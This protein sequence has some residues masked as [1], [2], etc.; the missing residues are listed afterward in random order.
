MTEGRYRRLARHLSALG[1]GYPDEDG[2]EEILMAGY[3]PE[4]VEVALGLPNAVPPLQP[5]SMAAIARQ[6][7]LPEARLMPVLETMVQKG[8]L[9]TGKTAD[10]ERGYALQQFGWGFPQSWFW[11]GEETPRARD[12]ADLVRRYHTHEVLQ[13]G[14]GGTGTKAYRFVPVGE[15]ALVHRH[16]GQQAVY[17]FHMMQDLIGQAGV[18]AVAHCP[19][20]MIARLRGKGCEHP[21]EVCLK[22]DELAEY[23]IDTGRGRRVS[24]D[25][26]LQIVRQS[27]ALGMVHLVDNALEKVK[28][29][30]NCCPCSCWSVN[31]LRRRKIPRDSLMATYFLR[32]TDTERCTGCG[33]CVEVCPVAAL[34]MGT[35]TPIIDRDW[36]I[37]CGVC[38]SRCPNAAAILEPRLE[39]MSR[40]PRD[41]EEQ[42]SR[43]LREKG[44][45]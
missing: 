28:H 4:E 44:L 7:G 32:D 1:M 36:C 20:R 39:Q 40:I 43:I 25:E 12:M 24:Q 27:E 34:S 37:G 31:S 41:F 11:G 45:R 42:Q 35:E 16:D 15:T 8:L 3:S 33:E 5:V 22:Y 6:L 38:V 19:C 2:L 10:G 13:K 9:F 14:Y 29:S 30:C 18:I 23:V 17:P 21:L 26:A